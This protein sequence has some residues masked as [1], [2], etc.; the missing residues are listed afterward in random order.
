MDIKEKIEQIV[1]Q[2]KNDKEL[3]ELFRTEPIKAVEKVLGVDLP[4]DMINQ[5]VEGV[6]AKISVDKI[7]DAF[8]AFKKLF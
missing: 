7:S 1:E 2:I 4:D 6:K 8:G 3:Q 5:I